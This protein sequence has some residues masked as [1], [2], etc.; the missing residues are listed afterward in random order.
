MTNFLAPGA[1]DLPQGKLLEVKVAELACRGRILDH[2]L[3]AVCQGDPF[4]DS[5]GGVGD[6]G[7]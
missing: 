6:L 2:L 3:T 4:G 5:Q 7:F 1:F